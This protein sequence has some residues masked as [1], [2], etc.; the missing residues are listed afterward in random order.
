MDKKDMR[1]FDMWVQKRYGHL[2]LYNMI[3]LLLA[4]LRSA[5]YFHPYYT[6]SIN[7]IVV[8]ALVLAVVLLDARSK[9]LYIAALMFWIITYFFRISGVEVWAERGAIYAYQSLVIATVIS[10]F[11]KRK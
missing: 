2:A 8:V 6:L 4:L 11:E 7:I 3:L 1:N 9:H 5:G 10:F